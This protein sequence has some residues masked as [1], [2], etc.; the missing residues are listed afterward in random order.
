MSCIF[1]LIFY[2]VLMISDELKRL[3]VRGIVFT[4]FAQERMISSS[5]DLRL[6]IFLKMIEP[7]M[8]IFLK[9]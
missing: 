4:I 1:F 8:V 9:V 6:F 5:L 7:A 3:V 2:L